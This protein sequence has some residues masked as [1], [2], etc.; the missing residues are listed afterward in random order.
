MPKGKIIFYNKKSKFGFIKDLAEDESYYVRE[1]NLIDEVQQDD[2]VEF[3][4]R[5]S[6]KGIEAVAV[7][8]IRPL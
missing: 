5:E 1:K 7:K 6:L 8:L 2:E 3:E 4:L